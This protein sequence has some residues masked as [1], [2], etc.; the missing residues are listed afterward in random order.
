MMLTQDD[1]ITLYEN[2]QNITE[3]MLVAARE[4]NWALFE[5]LGAKCTNEVGILKTEEVSAPL[6]SDQIEKKF[7]L[8]QSILG[9]DRAIRDITEP[10][11]KNLDALIGN[12]SNQKKIERFYNSRDF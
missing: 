7:K 3:E 6:S 12:T 1:V 2:V 11:M 5:E 4:K 9:T 8:I 10:W